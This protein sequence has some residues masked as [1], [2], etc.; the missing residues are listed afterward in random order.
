MEERKMFRKN[1]TFGFA[2]S[3]STLPDGTQ[4]AL[5]SS[6]CMVATGFRLNSSAEF[7]EV[8]LLDP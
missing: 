2:A 1:R 7:D 4:V 5:P 3:P 6:A 8:G